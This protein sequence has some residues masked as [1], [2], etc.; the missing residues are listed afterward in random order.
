M[1]ILTSASTV[2]E[3]HTRGFDHLTK[4]VDRSLAYCLATLKPNDGLPDTFAAIANFLMLSLAKLSIRHCTGAPL[5]TLNGTTKGFT[6]KC[7][8]SCKKVPDDRKTHQ[9]TFGDGRTGR[10]MKSCSPARSRDT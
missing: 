8:G 3:L 5:S 6:S 10:E 4:A 1:L 2:R 9:A 7:C